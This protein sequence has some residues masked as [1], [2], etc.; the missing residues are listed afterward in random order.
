MFGADVRRLVAQPRAGRPAA[1]MAA[2]R[3]G[4]Q[5]LIRWSYVP[6]F[7]APTNPAT[8]PASNT[9]AGPAGSLESRTPTSPAPPARA[10]RRANCTQL[11]LELLRPLLR[12]VTP[13][14]SVASI[15]FT[16]IPFAF[17]SLP[18]GRPGRRTPRPHP[19]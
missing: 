16:I 18:L 3:P 10:S 1:V 5:L 7:N 14:M 13:S 8:S 11:P 19:P 15:P 2:G 6:A 9:N 12:Q 17:I 4:S